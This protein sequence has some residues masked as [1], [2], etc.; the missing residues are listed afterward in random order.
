MGKTSPEGAVREEDFTQV[1]RELGKAL[2]SFS[3]MSSRHML[4]SWVLASTSSAVGRRAGGYGKALWTSRWQGAGSFLQHGNKGA[5]PG[6]QPEPKPHLQFQCQGCCALSPWPGCFLTD[7]ETKPRKRL[8]NHCLLTLLEAGVRSALERSLSRSSIFGFPCSAHPL[9]ATVTALL[10]QSPPH[11]LSLPAAAAPSA[12]A[13]VTPAA[14]C[15]LPG[16][17]SVSPGGS[18]AAAGFAPL[19]AAHRYEGLAPTQES[20]QPRLGTPLPHHAATSNVSALPGGSCRTAQV[21]IPSVLPG[22]CWKHQLGAAHW[23]WPTTQ[24]FAICEA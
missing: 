24:S 8:L 3:M 21:S 18:C 20:L 5:G 14:C 11:P 13:A 4:T 7:V 6:A 16:S 17:A 9:C 2:R 15:G 19:P 10:W 1:P 12:C 22:D 23:G